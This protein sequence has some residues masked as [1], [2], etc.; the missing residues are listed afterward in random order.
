M[1]QNAS[2]KENPQPVYQDFPKLLWKP[3]FYYHVHERPFPVL[4]FLLHRLHFISFTFILML[5][6]RLYPGFV[7]D[8]L[9]SGDIVYRKASGLCKKKC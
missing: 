3:R 4:D 5:Y 1:N 8:L 2:S 7:S 9:F 6:S